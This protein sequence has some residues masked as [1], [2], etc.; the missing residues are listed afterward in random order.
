[1]KSSFLIFYFFSVCPITHK[2][3]LQQGPD[4][5]IPLEN[6]KDNQLF[7]KIFNFYLWRNSL[8]RS[9]NTFCN[10]ILLFK[11]RM[12]LKYM[13]G[14]TSSTFLLLL[15]QRYENLCSSLCFDSW[16]LFK[17]IMPTNTKANALDITYC[18][19]F[20]SWFKQTVSDYFAQ[21]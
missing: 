5:K 9:K 8:N 4:I 13:D 15:T 19:I 7:L 6:N 10:M 21:N 3:W 11:S 14:V 2:I 1:M 18:T 17:F 12:R 16:S 20:G